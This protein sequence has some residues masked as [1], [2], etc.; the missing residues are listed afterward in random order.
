MM[1]NKIN[2]YID[3]KILFISL[4]IFIFVMAIVAISLYYIF[5]KNKKNNNRGFVIFKYHIK[6]RSLI[7]ITSVQ[8]N[9]GLSF[10]YGN[11]VILKNKFYKIN[12]L[13]FHLS[14]SVV[15]QINK[16]LV[17]QQPDVNLTLNSLLKKSTQNN[18][19]DK[20]KINSCIKLV[21][22]G[23]SDEFIITIHWKKSEL[24]PI[25]RKQNNYV[26]NV[27]EL[28]RD[29]K[30]KLISFV[31]INPQRTVNEPQNNTIWDKLLKLFGIR[32]REVKFL[33]WEGIL[34]L[35]FDSI[36]S[37]S[38][39][40][41]IEKFILKR[42]N[43][44]SDNL[45][46]NSLAKTA[47][48]VSGLWPQDLKN[49]TDYLMQSKY[50][51]L[52]STKQNLIVNTFLTPNQNTI[53]TDK[54]NE[55]IVKNTDF[56]Q[57]IDIGS[58]VK[59]YTPILDV[60]E[61]NSTEN[62]SVSLAKIA[63]INFDDVDFLNQID[64]IKNKYDLASLKYQIDTS[65]NTV[66]LLI[67]TSDSVLLN[68]FEKF[69]RPNTLFILRHQSFDFNFNDIEAILEQVAQYENI[70]IGLY[71][72]HINSKLK[73]YIT[74]DKIKHYVISAKLTE[75]ILNDTETFLKLVDFTKTIK[76]FDNVNIYWENL[77]KD[78]DHY[79]IEK[80]G[81]EYIYNNKYK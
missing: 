10:D 7:R 76:N 59:E 4:F 18:N 23:N 19:H 58:F 72:D 2:A 22:Y 30:T 53:D 26:A 62:Y 71:V 8:K 6:N 46:F 35:V 40:K 81:I 64:F 77:P 27:Q 1:T 67:I 32:S 80:L 50:A 38:K 34:F 47:T 48:L 31:A 9:S 43:K 42:I 55:F 5:A 3:S 13:Y 16:I 49:L 11:D 66:N 12:T 78:I 65:E 45:E 60:S 74:Q 73:E 75:K 70:N 33:F 61:K 79:Y 25:S 24:K 69:A 36:K 52:K 68:D 63:G 17:E 15:S 44:L 39:L 37:P 41:T 56:E 29:N 21:R 54:F 28:L 51:L 20:K 14:E 57:K